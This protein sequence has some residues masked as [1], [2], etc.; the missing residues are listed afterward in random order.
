MYAT[1][2]LS[3]FHRCLTD[4]LNM[5]FC[6]T[7]LFLCLPV[8]GNDCEIHLTQSNASM[9]RSTCPYRYL[10]PRPFFHMRFSGFHYFCFTNSHFVFVVC[11]KGTKLQKVSGHLH[12]RIACF[13]HSSN[14]TTCPERLHE[15]F[16]SSYN[17]NVFH[18]DS[19]S[20]FSVSCITYVTNSLSEFHLSNFSDLE[21]A[22]QDSL[23][24]YLSPFVHY[25]SL[26]T[27]L[28]LVII[29]IIPLCCCVRRA[30]TLYNH[31]K[32]IQAAH[33]QDTAM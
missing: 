11:P 22:V 9:A 5:Y 17:T 12:I 31:S 29:I 27:S 33:R 24:A 4:H 23:P 2:S 14:L 3:D 21:S 20:D 7:S 30:L 6:S 28:V 26:L 15:G 25:P 18:I 8:T 1:G 10:V 32:A 19:L 16:T 13:L